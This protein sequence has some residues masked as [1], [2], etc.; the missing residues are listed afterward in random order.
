MDLIDRRLGAILLGYAF[1]PTGLDAT[2]AGD[3]TVRPT[4]V[5]ALRARC[6][7]Y[8]HRGVRPTLVAMD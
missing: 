8:P 7:S 3:R 6:G 5:P 4:G 2:P 1:T